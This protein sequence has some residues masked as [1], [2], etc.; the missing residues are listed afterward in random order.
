MTLDR[1]RKLEGRRII[2]TGAA[3][4]MGAVMST[5][6]LTW[7]LLV[8]FGIYNV[9]LAQVALALARCV[10]LHGVRALE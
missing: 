3:S 8:G 2:V 5:D 10:K 7:L 1:N 4:G 6:G 9:A